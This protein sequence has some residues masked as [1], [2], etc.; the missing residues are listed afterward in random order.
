M[1]DKERAASCPGTTLPARVGMSEGEFLACSEYSDRTVTT[2]NTTTT[3]SGVGSQYVYSIGSRRH[4][5]YFDGGVL[6]ATSG[7]S[8]RFTRACLSAQPRDG[9][10]TAKVMPRRGRVRPADVAQ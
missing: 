8:A 5:I 1:R 6:T 4:Y 9:S 2:I 7:R 3:A 10:R